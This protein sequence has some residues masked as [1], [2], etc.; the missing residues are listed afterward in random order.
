MQF[1]INSIL[2]TGSFNASDLTLIERVRNLGAGGIEFSRLGFDDFPIQAIRR[3]LERLDMECTLCTT[4]PTPEL[5]LIHPEPSCRVAGIGYLREAISVAANIGSKLLV[6][7]LY[8]KVGWFPGVKRTKEQFEWAVEGFRSLVPDLERRNVTLA[9]EPLNRF[10]SFF[11]ATAA[12]GRELC[13]AVGSDRV[14]LLLDTAHMTIEE[15]SLSSAIR[16]AGPWLRHMHT[17]ENDRGTPGTGL[18]SW[19]AVFETLHEINYDG[20]CVVETFSWEDPAVARRTH[21]WRTLAESTDSLGREGLSFLR[22]TAM[23]SKILQPQ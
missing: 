15:K 22:D 9:I 8:G 2:W 6:G 14:G 20:W 7:P 21:T 23:R 13:E 18:V 5:S 3:E 19:P 17:V 10:E 12:D 4:P 11:L 1:G 16:I